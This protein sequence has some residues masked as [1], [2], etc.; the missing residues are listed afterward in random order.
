MRPNA[1]MAA[2]ARLGASL[3]ALLGLAA[4]VLAGDRALLDVIGYS[5]DGRYFAFEEYG[6]QD[7]SGFAYSSI[8]IVDLA[9]DK[10]MYG[11][12]FHA[13]AD[14]EMETLLAEVRAEARE[15][16]DERL[17]ELGINQ[18]AE[19]L[20]LLG[21][22][23]QDQPGKT[24]TFSNP[25]WGPPG[26]TEEGVTYALSLATFPAKSSNDCETLLGKPAVGYALDLN[27]Q[28]V[29]R[30]GLTLP[31]SRG[32]PMDYRLYAVVTPFGAAGHRVAIIS[33]YPYGFEGPDR[34]FLAVPLDE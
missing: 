21:D 20:I 23:V 28:E 3:L 1:V 7:G 30:D 18:P 24:M 29:H 32:C 19:I 12:P 8:Y 2:T 17:V 10:W 34:R 15:K 33:S 11:S 31:K 27:G 9:A 5:E 6:V 16:A 13:Q 14:E 22:G 4:P 26:S 25:G